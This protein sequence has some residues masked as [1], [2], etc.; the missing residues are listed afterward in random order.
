M[1]RYVNVKVKVT[2]QDIRLGTPDSTSRDAVSLALGRVINKKSYRVG[3]WFTTT[4]IENRKTGES[5]SL[6]LPAKVSMFLDH[7][8]DNKTRAKPITFVMRGVPTK[9]LKNEAWK[10][11][12]GTCRTPPLGQEPTAEVE[13][14]D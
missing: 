5:W 11:V 8:D 3:T 10:N 4:E 2:P 12:V 1:E 13:F 7:F 9:A 6:Q 14:H